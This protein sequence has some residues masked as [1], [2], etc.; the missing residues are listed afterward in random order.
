MLPLEALLGADDTTGEGGWKVMRSSRVF[1]SRPSEA[2]WTKGKKTKKPAVLQLAVAPAVM[3][4]LLGRVGGTS[5]ED[6]PDAR[7]K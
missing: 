5:N 7:L 2:H 4:Q 1:F 3:D 6:S